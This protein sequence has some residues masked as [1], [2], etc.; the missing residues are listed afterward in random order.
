[1]F[2]SSWLI[3]NIRTLQ[4][5]AYENQGTVLDPN[6][7][8]RSSYKNDKG[9]Y[10]FTLTSM[11]NRTNSETGLPILD[12]ILTN[13][14]ETIYMMRNE[15]SMILPQSYRI[16][17]E[18]V[19][20]CVCIYDSEEVVNCLARTLVHLAWTAVGNCRAVL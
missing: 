17:S 1:M 10:Y 20:H 15:V 3:S 11:L 4:V 2:V 19:V 16:W 18:L 6:Y 5:D 13:G 9:L 7:V 12:V 14:S 8:Y